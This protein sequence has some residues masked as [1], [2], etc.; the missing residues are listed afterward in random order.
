[1]GMKCKTSSTATRSFWDVWPWQWKGRENLRI[2]LLDAEKG[3][4]E[5][6]GA[7]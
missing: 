6:E 4:K 5:K 2:S 3:D 7:H 1:M